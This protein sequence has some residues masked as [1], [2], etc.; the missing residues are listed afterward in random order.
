MVIANK[1][2]YKIRL[3]AIVMLFLSSIKLIFGDFLE[4]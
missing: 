4:H 2:N 1:I 3:L